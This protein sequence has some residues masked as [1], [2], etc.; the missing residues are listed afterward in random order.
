MGLL[1]IID[2]DH[3]SD[4]VVGPLVDLARIAHSGGGPGTSDRP[5]KSQAVG[6][7]TSLKWTVNQCRASSATSSKAP[8]SSKRWV[9]PGT[10]SSLFFASELGLGGSV[11]VED[12]GVETTHYQQHG[13]SNLGQTGAGEIRSAASGDD[14]GDVDAW[15]GSRSRI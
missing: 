7:V 3:L 15:L 6:D 4:R 10:T 14:R 5:R 9:A 2:V 8:G 11:Q 1:P 12:D 13:Y